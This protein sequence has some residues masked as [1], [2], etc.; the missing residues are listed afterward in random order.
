VDAHAQDFIA[1][2]KLLLP[3]LKAFVL[4]LLNIQVPVQCPCRLYSTP[5]RNVHFG[6]EYNHKLTKQSNTQFISPQ[7]ETPDDFGLCVVE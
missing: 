7:L 6:L 2:D 5:S 3:I 4:R 1:N